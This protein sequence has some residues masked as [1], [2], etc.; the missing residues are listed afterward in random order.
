M[1]KKQSAER[2]EEKK[3]IISNLYRNT[4]VLEKQFELLDLKVTFGYDITGKEP[5]YPD[6]YPYWNYY[7]VDAFVEILSVNST[8]LDGNYIVTMNL[9][10]ENGCIVGSES[11]G[12]KGSKFNEFHMCKFKFISDSIALIAKKTKILISKNQSL[13]L[14]QEG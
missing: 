4:E 2:A 7:W 1:E 14:R 5:R 9:Y 11:S 12:F 13:S 10:D 3:I 6:L 8:K